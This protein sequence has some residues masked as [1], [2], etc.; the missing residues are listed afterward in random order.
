MNSTKKELYLQLYDKADKLQKELDFCKWENGKCFRGRSCCS[1]CLH[2]TENGCSIKNL[3][4]KLWRCSNIKLDENN[5]NK[6][7]EIFFEAKKLGLPL[8]ARA[9]IDEMLLENFEKTFPYTEAIFDEKIQTPIFFTK[10]N[11]TN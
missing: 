10:E 1:T 2:V 9:S 3:V 4:C 7:K 11:T 5:I 8:Y 6:I